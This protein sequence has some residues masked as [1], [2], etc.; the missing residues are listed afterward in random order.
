MC[1]CYQLHLA[2]N[3]ELRRTKFSNS[4]GKNTNLI[5]LTK[6]NS[7][8]IHFRQLVIVIGRPIVQYTLQVRDRYGLFAFATTNASRVHGNYLREEA[9]FYRNIV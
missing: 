8:Y 7:G 4:Q 5:V 6:Q 1:V 2:G 9:H 3:V